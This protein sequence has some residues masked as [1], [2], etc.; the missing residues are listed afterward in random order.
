MRSRFLP[1]PLLVLTSCVLPASQA[2][3]TDPLEEY[4]RSTNT[5]GDVYN[6]SEQPV[7]AMLDSAARKHRIPTVLLRGLAWHISQWQQKGKETLSG[8]VG[9]MA[10]PTANR[11]PEVVERLKNDT[12]FNIEEGARLLELCWNRAP[13]IGNGHLD[14]G[15]N[16]L[17]CWYFALG[18]YGVMPTG[19]RRQG[20]DANP[21]ADAVL[22]TLASLQASGQ[23]ERWETTWVT[24]PARAR[25]AQ[26]LNLYGAPTPWHFGDVAPRAKAVP[27]VSLTVPYLSQVWDSPDS[28]D[29]GGSC[30]PTSLLM[31]M[32]FFHK[33]QPEPIEVHDSYLHTTQY[34]NLIPIVHKAVCEPGMGAVHAKML[35][36]LRP[37]FPDVAIFYN[38]KASYDRVKKELD[39]GRPVILGTQ[40]TPAG[41]IMVAR[42]YLADGRLL[43]NDPAGDRDQAARW[44]SPTGGYSPTGVR[45]WNGDGD[46]ATYDWDALEIRWVM[47]VGPKD[48][49]ADRAEDE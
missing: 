33:I 49:A 38:E 37:S 40:V 46:K 1:L 45:Y 26:A 11:T 16:I 31:L 5:L 30:G 23:G 2:Q 14:E 47:T 22:D 20:P 48:P 29:G 13:I 43:V 41:H 28:F 15:R 3:A 36:Y 24:R 44:N 21:F 17:E 8:R 19:A 9:I 39:A 18:R 12:Q 35:S 6:V 32:A 4:R 27:I 34:G 10:V 7:A 25:L 42:G